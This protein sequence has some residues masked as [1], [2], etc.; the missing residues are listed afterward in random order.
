MYGGRRN[1]AQRKNFVLVTQHLA[2][3]RFYAEAEGRLPDGIDSLSMSACALGHAAL[4]RHGDSRK[5]RLEAL[6]NRAS[7]MADLRTSGELSQEHLTL[8][9]PE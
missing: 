3:E 9:E 4:S 5:G 8:A 1:E 2:I 7:D 6:L